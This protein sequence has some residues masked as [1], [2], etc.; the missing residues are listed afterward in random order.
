M[1]SKHLVVIWTLAAACSPESGGD[2]TGE[3]TADACSDGRD[4]DDDGLTDCDDPAC[5][6]FSWCDEGPD[7]DTDVD[8][9]VDSDVDADSDTDIDADSDGDTGP[10]YCSIDVVFVIDVSTSMRDEV[11]GIRAG[12]D[13][14]WAAALELTSDTR[15]GLVVFVDDVVAVNG[16]APFDT[17]DALQ[18][19]LERW[20]EF[21]SS[22][23][24]PGGAEFSN[25]DCPENS[26][27]ALYT[28]ATACAW[29]DD[30][31][32]IAIHVTDDTFAERP[33]RLSSVFGMGGIP[34][35]HTYDE[36]RTALVE[37]EVRLG[38][39]AAPGAGEYCGAGT[40]PNVGQGF[41]E[42]Y[43]GQ[44]SLPEATGGRAFDIRAV[45]AG[46]L[47]MAE[48]INQL[49]EEEYCTPYVY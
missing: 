21:T 35:Q 4:N 3:S 43:N 29:R 40:S 11:E 9:D 26:L 2:G 32:R 49:I 5:T 30:A 14:I 19:E 39:F 31:T 7:A 10:A 44:P 48:A 17:V 38:A 33:R 12:I 36:V 16:C 23:D 34:V 6:V 8:S 13:S 45:R 41:H 1:W 22:N 47:D 24:Q 46:T 18:S 25:T 15:F 37:H 20:R 28:A 27:D 42:P